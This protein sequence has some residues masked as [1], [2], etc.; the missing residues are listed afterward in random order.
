MG[1]AGINPA[2]RSIGTCYDGFG[3][4]VDA[5]RQQLQFAFDPDQEIQRNGNGKTHISDE[6]NQL[7]Q[8]ITP[9]YYYAK[10]RQFALAHWKRQP[11][12]H[13]RLP[14]LWI[15]GCYSLG[16]A[17]SRIPRT[18]R[19]MELEV[20]MRINTEIKLLIRSMSISESLRF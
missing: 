11:A 15:A 7:V 16:H 4:I 13:G 3:Q 5:F 12:P 1:K 18:F 19:L 6:I 20:A 14:G 10:S 2:G 9:F 17:F 8:N